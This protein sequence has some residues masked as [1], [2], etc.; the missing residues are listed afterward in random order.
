MQTI[1]IGHKN[2]DM[3]SIC[4]ALAYAR[5]KQLLGAEDII[6][7]RAGNTNARIDYVL[8]RF[9]VEAPVF[10]TDVAPTVADVMQCG[11]ACVRADSAIYDAIQ[12]IDGHTRGLPVVDEKRRCVGLLSTFKLT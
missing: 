4:S 8:D 6:A 1:V 3:D 9:G 11:G 12:L 7:A 5:L 2:P 10:L